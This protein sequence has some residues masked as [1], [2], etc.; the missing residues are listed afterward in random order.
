[1]SEE[2]QDY[3]E[4]VRYNVLE[5]VPREASSI[6]SVGCGAGATEEILV[7]RGCEVTGIEMDQ[8]AGETA[9]SRG[10][11]LISCEAALAGPHLEGKSFDC[12]IYADVLEHLTEPEVL[13]KQQAVFLKPGGVVVIS[14][15]NFRNWEVL[16]QL[17]AKGEVRYMDAG[18]LDRTHLRITTRKMVITWLKQAGLDPVEHRM[19]TSRKWEIRANFCSLNLLREFFSQQAI[20]KAIK[21]L[22][23]EISPYGAEQ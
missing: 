4:H 11:N 5:F 16:F 7:N 10:I 8:V 3:Y 15:P 20:V 1:M 22:E 9:Q 18:I 17:I 6:L 19:A 21:P 2:N 12:L 14:V 23:A 13:L